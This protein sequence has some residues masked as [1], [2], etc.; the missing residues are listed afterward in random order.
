[1]AFCEIAF[2]D[3]TENPF[4][5]I[6][7]DWMLIT[8]GTEEKCNTMTASWGGLGVLWNIPVAFTFIR[9]Q[10]YTK[11]FVDA[12][13]EYSLCFFDGMHDKLG[14]LGKVSGRDE[15]K[16]EKAGLTVAVEDGVPY[17]KEA[18]LVLFCRKK[19]RQQMTPEAMLDSDII[20]K[21]Y[22]QND[23]HEMYVGE[24]TKILKKEV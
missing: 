23:F 16:I 1:M 24:V 2:R 12:Q 10:R 6:G 15:D 7:D 5:L 18:R 14:Y 4:S 3:L 20:A 9:P 13:E 22:P 21:F 19:Y 8:A 17:F 11:E